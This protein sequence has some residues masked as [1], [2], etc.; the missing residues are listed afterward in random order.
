MDSQQIR[1]SF[2]DFYQR[3]GHHL[4]AGGTLLPPAGDT[5]LLTTSGMHSLT[6]YLQ[7][8][9]HPHGPRLVNLQRCL[10]TTDLEEVGDSTHLTTFQMLGTWSLGDYSHEQSLRW[11]HELLTGVFGVDPG[12]LHATVFGGDGEVEPDLASQRV[13]TEFGVPVELT[14]EDNWW[15]N[16][17]TGPC[18]PDSEIF[19]WTGPGRPVG[20]PTTDSRW[21]EIWNHVSMCHLRDA[22]GSLR[23]LGRRNVDTG[24]G[25]ERFTMLLQGHE[26]VFET[27]LFEPWIRHVTTLWPLTGPSRRIAVDH[28]RSSLVLLGDGVTP[29]NKGRGYV[30]RRLLR[31]VL[32]LLWDVDTSPTLGD[33]PAELYSST[34]AQFDLSGGVDE[35]RR[36]REELLAE[37]IRYRSLLRRG[38][39]LVARRLD[40]EPPTE[41]DLAYLAQTHGLPR[42]LVLGLLLP[43]RDPGEPGVRK[44]AP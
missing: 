35:A 29:A 3:R 10:R 17:P 5:V 22:D 24:M 30:L 37:E 13:W 38:R 21:V 26:S 23:P 41:R 8:R 33:L 16:G 12:R 19:L 40:G 31:R 15:S 28:L 1:S 20:T 25:L 34:Q 14:A 7:G 36:W 18:G 43:S 4:I 6:P 32:T 42:D 9:P 44:A 2:V 27:D 11:A 39:A